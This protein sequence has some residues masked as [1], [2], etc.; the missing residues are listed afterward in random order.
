MLR[1]EPFQLLQIVQRFPN[2]SCFFHIDLAS[3]VGCHR[4]VE[5]PRQFVLALHQ[6]A[7]LVRGLSDLRIVL[8]VRDVRGPSRMVHP[9]LTEQ[10]RN[11]DR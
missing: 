10:N 3:F 6:F 11:N 8:K 5:G 1:L 4:T 2:G 7:F 9:G